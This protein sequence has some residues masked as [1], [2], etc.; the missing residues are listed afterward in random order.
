MT[1]KKFTGDEVFKHTDNH[2]FT[3]REFWSYCLSNLESNF[4]RGRLAKFI[5]INALKGDTSTD[6][7]I[8][9]MPFDVMYDGH[10]IAV[11][12]SAYIHNRTEPRRTVVSWVSLKAE[13]LYMH[14]GTR[15]DPDGVI[16]YPADVYVLALLTHTDYDTLD[17]TNLQQWCFYVLTR[18]Q[19]REITGNKND[20]SLTKIERHG[21]T[22][23]SFAGLRTA[24][25]AC[26][27]S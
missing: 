21:L 14:P 24:V 16:A 9:K 20:I 2:H 11:K 17:A 3:V 15:L 26:L 5:V 10:K 8:H 25:D 18:D 4:V 23:V 19:V 7:H 27:S 22:P 1:M 12:S 13:D 6:V